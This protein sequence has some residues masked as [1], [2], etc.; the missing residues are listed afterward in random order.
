MKAAPR[1]L[2]VDDERFFREGICDALAAA[3]IASVTAATGSE[4]LELASD[5]AIAAVVLDLVLPG[6]DGLEVLRRLRDRQPEVPV[7]MLSAYSDQPRVLE[8]LRLGAFE[9][10]A[11]PLHDEELTLTVRRA[12]ALH[13]VEQG[14]ARLRARVAALDRSLA[15]LADIAVADVD[16]QGR[17]EVLRARAAAAAAEVLEA[18][19]TSLLLLSDDGAHL[20]VV[21]ATGRKQPP[22]EFDPVALGTGAAGMAVARSEP[23][24]VNDVAADP[25][26]AGRTVAGRYESAAFAV[27][28]VTSGGRTVGALCATDRPGG[29]PFEDADLALLKILARSLGDALAAR[30]DGVLEAAGP[31]EAEL[32][33]LTRRICDATTAEIDPGRLLG[34][35]LRPVAEALGA[36]PVSIYLRD[37]ATG[38]LAREAECDGAR[39]SD[40]QRLPRGR[41]LTGAVLETGRPVAAAS[42]AGDARFDL[43]ADTPE[44]GAAGPLLCVPLVVRGR[45]LGVARAFPSDPACCSAR[46]AEVLCAALSAAVR[47]A[48]LSRSLVEA[49]EEVASVR[50]E[51]RAS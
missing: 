48:L 22:E 21:A 26:F 44:D 11:K 3:G 8:A 32:A 39:R 25:R 2:V 13:A 41:G 38:D 9:Y 28:P 14:L 19:K 27:A 50:R 45:V 29:R 24:V 35:V 37:A 5:P 6:M 20:R 18:G 17:Q 47:T 23:V 49:V 33:E 34:A 4:A 10:L 1:V 31:G 15:D 43:A 36:A 7:I 16:E 40:R 12:F 46:T 42:P 30:A 51:S